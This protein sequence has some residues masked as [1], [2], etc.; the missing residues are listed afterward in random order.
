MKHDPRSSLED[1]DRA[2]GLIES[3]ISNLDYN[4]FENDTKTISAVERQFIIIGEATNRLHKVAPEIADRIL[5]MQEIIGFRNILAHDYDVVETWEVW[6]IANKD[7]PALRRQVSSMCAQ[8][9]ETPPHTLHAAVQIGDRDTVRRCLRAGDDPN[10]YDDKGATALH[11]AARYNEVEITRELLAAGADPTLASRQ[12]WTALHLAAQ[13]A[14]PAT[15]HA[16]I[17]KGVDLTTVGPDKST[18]LHWA[19]RN[20]KLAKSP[21]LNRLVPPPAPASEPEPE[22]EPEPDNGP[23]FDM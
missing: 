13:W 19:R 11:W 20:P 17:S 6:E 2:A 7:L 10:T 1:I 9:E 18:A 23:S 12:G 21:A 16:L 15:V 22:P 14:G 3:F 5:A 4:S 8:L